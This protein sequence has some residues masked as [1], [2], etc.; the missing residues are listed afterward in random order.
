MGRKR[1]VPD[2]EASNSAEGIFADR[3]LVWVFQCSKHLALHCATL[4]AKGTNLPAKVCA[5]GLWMRSGQLFVGPDNLKSVG[6]DINA[7]KVGIAD[8]GFY[9]WNADLEPL[10]DLCLMR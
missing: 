9:L 4:D 6:V 3:R 2:S 7:L 5:G 10:P 8:D 1:E